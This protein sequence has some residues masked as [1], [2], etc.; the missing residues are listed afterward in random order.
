[1]SGIRYSATKQRMAD[2]IMIQLGMSIQKPGMDVTVRG[3]N[4]KL[5]VDEYDYLMKQLGLVSIIVDRNGK[6]EA[7]NIQKAIVEKARSPGFYDDPKDVQQNNIREV[8]SQFTKMAQAEL[9]AHPTFGPRI[10]A[11]VEAAQ[12]RRARVGNYIK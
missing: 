6:P 10:E 12:R 2:K 11:R 7:L 4:V 8:Y 1:M 3:V 5:E 9:Y